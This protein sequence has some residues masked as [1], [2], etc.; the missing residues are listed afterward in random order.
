[1]GAYDEWWKDRTLQESRP[2]SYWH[3][4]IVASY[5][6]EF[7]GGGLRLRPRRQQQGARDVFLGGGVGE[8]NPGFW[9]MV[10]AEGKTKCGFARL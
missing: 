3:I 10:R 9:V 2:D 7:I 4:G 8:C 6:R 1:M 5:G